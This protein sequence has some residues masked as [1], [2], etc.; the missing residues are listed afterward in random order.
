MTILSRRARPARFLL[1]TGLVAAAMA[2][3][4]GGAAA[5]PPAAFTLDPTSLAFGSIYVNSSATQTVTVTTGRKAV[6]L[7][8]EF[9]SGLYTDAGTGTCLSSYTYEVPGGTSCT[10]DVTFAPLVA[11]DFPATMTVLSCMK[12]HAVNGLPTCDMSHFSASVGL[13]GSG[14]DL[15]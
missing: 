3:T 15:P 2:L 8:V 4:A 1:A 13:T 14:L 6:V 11:H 9:D 12:W 7:D 10:I 5:A